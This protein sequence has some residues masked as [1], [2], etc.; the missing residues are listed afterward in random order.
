MISLYKNRFSFESDNGTD[1]FLL[2]ILSI[3]WAQHKPKLA[4]FFFYLNY[5]SRD[6]FLLGAACK[7][8]P[9]SSPNLP[10]SLRARD[11]HSPLYRLQESHNLSTCAYTPLR[12]FMWEF[13]YFVTLILFHPLQNVSSLQHF[14]FF[15]SRFFLLCLLMYI[16]PFG[17]CNFYNHS[18][19]SFQLYVCRNHWF[20][21]E[22]FK[23]R[24]V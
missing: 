6:Y 9:S 2:V 20:C 23:Q 1:L 15:C 10:R 7:C 5:S 12:S 17:L 16:G 21:L 8:K 3:V 14:H 22:F 24:S 11:T 18:V 19:L 4:S 13:D